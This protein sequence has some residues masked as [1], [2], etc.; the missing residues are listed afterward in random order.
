VHVFQRTPQWISPRPNYGRPI[1][2]EVRWLFDN[3]P[4]YWNW[5]RYT[6]IIGLFTWHED[7][8]IP[9]PEWERQGGH[10]T[11][12]SEALRDFLIEYIREQ[13][14][15]R[16]DLIEKLIPDYAPM[17]RRP[18]VD[19]GWYKALT[20]E[21]VELVTDG[22]ARLTKT[23]IETVDGKHRDVDIIVF[24][25]GFDVE[26]YLWPAEYHGENG[27]NLRKFWSESSPRAY[28][29]MLVPRF[30]N[31]FIMYGPN[32]Q[33]VS[34]GVS[35]PSWFQIWAAYVGR[36]LITL[37]EGGYSKVAVSESA[38]EEYNARLDL[39]ASGLAFITDKRSVERNYY[40]DASGRVLV[41][42]PFETA[43]LYAMM[44]TLNRDEI[45]F[46]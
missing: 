4:G 15:G 19:N 8:L 27:A 6:S 17:V 24:A 46:S 9:D 10:I 16:S 23:G 5:C 7:F 28:L 45:E 35:L 18:V 25:T 26:K 34:G 41:N 21:N 2:P 43:D 14:D 39:E 13:T 31:L 36:C 11:R 37:I 1:E 40:V 12:Q 22:I 30:P 3:V 44:K 29:G 38:F 33:P 42:T 32:S 20:R